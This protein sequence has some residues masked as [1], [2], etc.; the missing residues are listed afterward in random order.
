MAFPRAVFVAPERPEGLSSAKDLYV[1]QLADLKNTATY[2]R[3]H[4]IFKSATASDKSG[5]QWWCNLAVAREQSKFR[6]YIARKTPTDEIL[7]YAVH[8]YDSVAG[9]QTASKKPIYTLAQ[10]LVD[11]AHQ[12]K[13]VGWRLVEDFFFCAG[14][15][16]RAAGEVDP[17]LGIS[18]FTFNMANILAM[19]GVAQWL[20]PLYPRWELVPGVVLRSTEA[21][22]WRLL[23]TS[24]EEANLIAQ[25]LEKYESTMH[26]QAQP[27]TPQQFAQLRVCYKDYGVEMPRFLDPVRMQEAL[28]QP[29]DIRQLASDLALA[30]RTYGGHSVRL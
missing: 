2:D 24:A 13:R 27:L 16:A 17:T 1:V 9:S 4:A 15:R 19:M 30:K 22:P 11:P 10:V 21:L 28:Q 18:S 14:Q 29:T 6:V 23:L 26:P 20:H 3:L 7:G 5:T 8:L 25:V 12:R